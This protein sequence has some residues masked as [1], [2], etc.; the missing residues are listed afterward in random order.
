MG[1]GE[2][3]G[4]PA[5][6]TSEGSASSERNE[7][8]AKSRLPGKQKPHPHPLGQ[9]GCVSLPIARLREPGFEPQG[10]VEERAPRAG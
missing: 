5:V 1:T 8:S 2:I 6:W 7:E 10:C 4:C 3:R 9:G